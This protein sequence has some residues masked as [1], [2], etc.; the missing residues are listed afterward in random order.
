[1]NK[2]N[3]TEPRKSMLAKIATE[4]TDQ[5]IKSVTGAGCTLPSHSFVP[6]EDYCP[7]DN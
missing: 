7:N 5:E 6:D 4:L 1:M 2:M 3:R